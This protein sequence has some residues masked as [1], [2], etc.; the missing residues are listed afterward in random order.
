MTETIETAS[1]RRT[2]HFCLKK[3]MRWSFLLWKKAQLRSYRPGGVPLGGGP[4]GG[5]FRGSPLAQDEEDIDAISTLSAGTRFNF[6]ALYEICFFFSMTIAWHCHLS[7]F[8]II[9][10]WHKVVLAFRFWGKTLWTGLDVADVFVQRISCIL[11]VYFPYS[12]WKLFL[13]WTVWTAEI[14]TPFVKVQLA[15][16]ERDVAVALPW[17]C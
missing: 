17:R 10:V 6:G 11:R 5:A 3:V 15:K 8:H 16:L 13:Y 14:W 12:V 1:I 7:L 9:S 2:C 4:L